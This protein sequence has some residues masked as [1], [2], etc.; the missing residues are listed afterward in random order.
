MPFFY[1]KKP[2]IAVSLTIL[3]WLS[4]CCGIVEKL[5]EMNENRGLI[6]KRSWRSYSGIWNTYFYSELTNLYYT[7]IVITLVDRCTGGIGSHRPNPVIHQ[8]RYFSKNCSATQ[9]PFQFLDY[10]RM[11]FKISLINLL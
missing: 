7:F 11:R 4:G 1:P 3:M 9:N 8:K 10:R 6:R 5:D 2:S